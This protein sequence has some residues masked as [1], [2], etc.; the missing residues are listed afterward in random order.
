M[1]VD[2]A[3][4]RRTNTCCTT[5]LIWTR[6]VTHGRRGPYLI[7]TAC[8]HPTPHSGTVLPADCCITSLAFAAQH[9]ACKEDSSR[10][11]I[12]HLIL[13][14]TFEE[15]GLECMYERRAVGVTLR[16]EAVH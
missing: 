1:P 7:A 2:I 16:P 14:A 12:L 11:C 13:S 3:A 15:F 8:I 9:A 10:E 5:M 4:A 6:S